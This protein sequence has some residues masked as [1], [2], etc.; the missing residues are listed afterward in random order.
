MKTTLSIL[1]IA[2]ANEAMD[3]VASWSRAGKK[4]RA[5]AREREREAKAR[6]D[7]MGFE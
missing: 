6:R 5:E 1:D 7:E 3:F 4:N 2:D